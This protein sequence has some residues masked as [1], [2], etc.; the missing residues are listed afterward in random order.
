M[1]LIQALRQQWTKPS[2]EGD[3]LYRQR[4]IKWRREPSTQRIPRPTRLDRAR[5]LGYAAKQGILI[6]RQRVPRGGHR[7]ER[8]RGGKKPKRSH[9][10]LMLDKNYRL[11]AEE[12][13]GKKF[14]NCEVL[15]SYFVAEDGKHRWFEIIL[16]DKSHPQSR[17]DHRYGWL[18]APQHKGRVHR[19]LTAAGKRSRGLRWKGKGAEKLRPSRH[20]KRVAKY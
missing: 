10:R 15:N 5:A 14:K 3:A 8:Y 7:R 13:A 18:N 6:V 20:A 19:G 11:I 1:G 12:R 16:V 4:L 17:A 2:A 9:T